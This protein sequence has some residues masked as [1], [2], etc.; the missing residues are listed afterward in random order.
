MDKRVS[1][2]EVVMS[3]SRPGEASGRGRRG[4]VR[5]GRGFTLSEILVVVV[6]IV[7]VASLTV[8]VFNVLSGSRSIDA[9]SNTIST[10]LSRAR[11]E[12]IARQRPV[13]LAVF[14][15][16]LR[17]R[18]AVALVSSP[19]PWEPGVTYVRGDVV[20]VVTTLVQ[21]ARGTPPR[22]YYFVCHTTHTSTTGDPA[23]ID[24]MPRSSV[25]G[26]GRWNLLPAVSPYN[27][28][29]PMPSASPPRRYGLPTYVSVI[30]GTELLYLPRGVGAQVLVSARGTTGAQLDRYLHAGVIF[31]GP[32]GR[33]MPERVWG[34][35]FNEVDRLDAANQ[36]LTSSRLGMLIRFDANPASTADTTN[37][38]PVPSPTSDRLRGGL[39]VILFDRQAYLAQGFPVWD[40]MLDPARNYTMG[41]PS[42][43][44]KETWLDQNGTL[45]MVNRFNGTLLRAE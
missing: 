37:L 43:Q 11:Q 28:E 44:Q 42:E 18:V 15:D 30:P 7:I 35:L 33:L 9:A 32:D 36:D 25:P 29:V 34:V 19:L 27:G 8:P 4:G 22:T 12:A 40:A 1:Q 14:T 10:M 38:D 2:P 20:S 31:F 5:G 6:I 39:G 24:G 17:D 26:S 45:L 13:G 23:D 16:V 41:S 21:D 3:A